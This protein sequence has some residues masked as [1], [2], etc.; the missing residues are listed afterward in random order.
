[1][2]KRIKNPI[3]ISIIRDAETEPL[4]KTTFEYGLE[5]DDGLSM[6]KG[7]TPELTPAEQTIIDRIVSKSLIKINEHEGVR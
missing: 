5:C 3:L 2:A 4:I 6:R 1:M 7:F